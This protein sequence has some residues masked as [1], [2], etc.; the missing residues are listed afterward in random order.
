MTKTRERAELA[1][2]RTQ[3]LARDR[4]MSEHDAVAMAR[5]EKTTRL[6]EMRKAKEA[7]DL[8]AGGAPQRAKPA[9]RAK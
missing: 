1:F 8:A 4:T 3:T 5:D 9:R 7:S 6:R 2:A